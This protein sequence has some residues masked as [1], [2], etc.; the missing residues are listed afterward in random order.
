M[1]MTRYRYF[2]TTYQVRTSYLVPGTRYVVLVQ[3]STLVI[4]FKECMRGISTN[5][6]NY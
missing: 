2:P 5:K 4:I 1:F 6:K 3:D